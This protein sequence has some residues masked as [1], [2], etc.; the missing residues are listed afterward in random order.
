MS[1][2]LLDTNVLISAIVFDKN[3]LELIIRCI[4]NSDQLFISKHIFKEAMR[5]FLAKFP[6]HVDLFKKFIE[7][8]K[9]K[10]IKKSAYEKS[11]LQFQNIRDRYDAHII[12]AAKAKR[13]DYIITGDKDILNYSLPKIKIMKASDFIKLKKKE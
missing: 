11:I 5:V 2:L 6:E 12:A 7:I 10:I 3:E 13:C 4:D 1:K 8:S 9:I